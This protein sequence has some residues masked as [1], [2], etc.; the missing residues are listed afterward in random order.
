MS[1]RKEHRWAISKDKEFGCRKKRER[2]TVL[3]L[4]TQTIINDE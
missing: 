3:Q 1:K 2:D 4:L